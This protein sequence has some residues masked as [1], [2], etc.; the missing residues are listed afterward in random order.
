MNFRDMTD[1]EL[2]KYLR[3]YAS[4]R[5]GEIADLTYAAGLRIAV[6]STRVKALEEEG[7]DRLPSVN[8]QEKVTQFADRCRECV[9]Q[10]SGQ[11]IAYEVRLPDRTILNYRCSV[12]GRKLIGYNTETLSEA[13]FCHCGAKM[14]EPQERSGGE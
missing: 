2:T 5:S 7:D 4:T 8:Q 9:K 3:D 11:W 10:K 12:C 13:P 14:V 1:D 6:L